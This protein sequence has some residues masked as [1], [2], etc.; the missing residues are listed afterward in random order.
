MWPSCIST[1]GTLCTYNDTG[2]GSHQTL[3]TCPYSRHH[4]RHSEHVLTPAITNKAHTLNQKKLLLVSEDSDTSVSE[5]SHGEFC[6]FFLY[7]PTGRPRRTALP[8][9][10][11]S[12]KLCFQVRRAAFYQGLERSRTGCGQAAALRINLNIDGC[13]V[14]APPV[15]F[16]SLRRDP[17]LLPGLPTLLASDTTSPFSHSIPFPCVHYCV[18]RLVAVINIHI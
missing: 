11:N 16:P 1:S 5:D 18:A 6:I 12:D 3:R 4:Y 14:V 13:G 7:R 9:P 15:H 10:H 8:S 17:L 2:F